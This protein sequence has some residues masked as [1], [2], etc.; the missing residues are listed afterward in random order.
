[1]NRKIRIAIIDDDKLVCAAFK[2]LFQQEASE[3]IEVIFTCNKNELFI[4]YCEEENPM[5]DVVLVDMS[6]ET[7][8][9]GGLKILQYMKDSNKTCKPIILTAFDDDQILIDEAKLLGAMS[10][11]KKSIDFSQL[12]DVIRKVDEGWEIFPPKKFDPEYNKRIEQYNRLTRQQKE[13]FK[14]YVKLSD[15]Y[16]VAKELNITPVTIDGHLTTIRNIF[17]VQ[18]D[19]NLVQIAYIIKI[20]RPS[21]GK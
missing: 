3:C 15:K 4:K 13:V 10:F 9:K 1:M 6:H 19:A 20:I 16:E 21:D 2:S 11:L 17:E 18:N 14:L 5:P 8:N 7:D 12:L